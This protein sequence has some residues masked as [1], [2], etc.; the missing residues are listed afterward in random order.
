MPVH[1]M[2]IWM[3]ESS[4]TCDTHGADDR[5]NC[6]GYAIDEISIGTQS[7]GGEFYDLVRHTADQDQTATICSSIDPWHE[8]PTGAD[9]SRSAWI[10]S[11]RAATRGLPA[12]I[13]VSMLYGT[14]R[15]R[16]RR[17]PI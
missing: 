5:R 3:T 7:A 12:M 2:R 14:P 8:P 17:S 11:T 16:P 6:V 15:M 1:V 10:S 13:P 9:E 4:N